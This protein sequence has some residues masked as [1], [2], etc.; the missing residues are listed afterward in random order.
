MRK[1]TDP[2]EAALSFQRGEEAGFEY[3]FHAYYHGLMWYCMKILHDQDEAED[4]VQMAFMKIWKKRATFKHPRVIQAWL[5]TTAK[6]YC[7]THLQVTKKI[8]SEMPEMVAELEMTDKIRMDTYWFL[9]SAFASLPEKARQIMK[10]LYF[11]D[12]SAK[13]VAKTLG[14]R[15]STVRNQKTRCLKILRKKFNVTDKQAAENDNIL[16]RKIFNSDKSP[17][18][19]E[20]L[21]GVLGHSSISQIKNGILY[22][23]ITNPQTT[24]Q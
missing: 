7:L 20:R 21:Y 12:M 1:I 18:M 13:D 9:Y 24:P 8:T 3:F 11:D 14:L 16:I 19:L 6:N 22:N 4:K 10:M 5:Y 2:Y 17:I 15:F 23:S